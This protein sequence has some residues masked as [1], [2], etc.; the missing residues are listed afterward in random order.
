[1]N[2]KFL[3]QPIPDVPKDTGWV[4]STKSA[5]ITTWHRKVELADDITPVMVTKYLY[6]NKDYPGW[7][8]VQVHKGLTKGNNVVLTSTYD[9]SG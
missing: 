5:C 9:S 4:V 6:D 3:N 7:T 2:D 1:M 8:G